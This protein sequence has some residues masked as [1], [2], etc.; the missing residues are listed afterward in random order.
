MRRMSL[1]TACKLTLLTVVIG[2]G[3]V[4]PAAAASKICPQYLTKYCVVT[5]SG[6]RH[7][8]ETNPCLARQR[9]WRIVHIGACRR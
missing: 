9:H 5:A 8:V 4:P 1:A 6:R 2:T 7:T 3:F